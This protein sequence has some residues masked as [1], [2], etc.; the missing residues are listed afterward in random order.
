MA[1]IHDSWSVGEDIPN[2]LVR[3]MFPFEDMLVDEALVNTETKLSMCE[4][5][6]GGVT[7]AEEKYHQCQKC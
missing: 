7:I 4:M 6:L 5:I 2:R 1:A 3:Y